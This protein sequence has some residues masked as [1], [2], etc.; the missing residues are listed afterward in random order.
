MKKTIALFALVLC[1]LAGLV[2]GSLALYTTSVEIDGGGSV[3]AKKFVLTAASS[4][5]YEEKV[6]IAPE[7]THSAL[8]IVYNYDEEGNVTEVDMDLEIKI[9]MEAANDKKL[10]PYITASLVD[11]KGNVTPGIVN[12]GD[13]KTTIELKV[14]RAFRAV[15]GKVYRT[16]EIKLYWPSHNDD[17]NYQGEAYGNKYTVIVTGTQAV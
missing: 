16:Y 4:T 2:S 7:E 14:D 17:I 3:V 15:D 13:G 9:E 8:F 1:I 6:K 10:I 11:D 12:T 5:G